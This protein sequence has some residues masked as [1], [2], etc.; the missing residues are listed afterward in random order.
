MPVKSSRRGAAWNGAWTGVGDRNVELAGWG[1][2]L[3]VGL[4]NFGR[5]GDGGEVDTTLGESCMGNR[6]RLGKGGGVE[7][8]G[9]RE[10]QVASMIQKCR[11]GW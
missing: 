5:A 10:A 6:G 4:A 3:H 9:S 11:G 7:G 2:G 1:G 8:A